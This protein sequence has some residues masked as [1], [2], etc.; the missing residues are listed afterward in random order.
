[1]DN[2]DFQLNIT[3]QGRLTTLDEFENIVV[4]ATPD[5]ALVR[6]KDIGRV[7]LGAKNSDSIGRYNG[8]VSDYVRTR[9]ARKGA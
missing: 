3:T 2:V 5:G 4:R 7:E 8:H 1:M 6:I 9:R